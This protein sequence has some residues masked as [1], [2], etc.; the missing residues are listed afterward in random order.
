M[1]AVDAVQ[2]VIIFV[3]KFGSYI[4]VPIFLLGAFIYLNSTHPQY[5]VT[6]KIALKGV[7]PQSA[8]S[9]LRSKSTVQKVIDQLP[10]QA[11]YYDAE[12]LREEIS[13]DSL[14][15]R[16]VFDRTSRVKAETWVRFELPGTD[17]FTLSYIDTTAW[18]E[19]D[20]HISESYG[21]F[22]VVRGAKYNH[23][24]VSYMVRLQDPATLFNEYYHDLR[25]S[26]DDD[27]NSVTLS[28]RTGTPQKGVEFLNK[29]ISLYRGSDKADSRYAGVN[30]K[31][32]LSGRVKLLEKPEN[33]VELATA[34]PFWIYLAAIVAGLL[35]PLTFENA[36]SWRRKKPVAQ[37]ISL[38]KMIV[39]LQHGIAVRQW[40]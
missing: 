40:D 16:L 13:A 9:D 21:G 23:I 25:F 1:I 34:D 6:A 18:Y 15:A 8:I 38:P 2:R 27:E 12:S 26:S 20:K 33:N 17:V 29:M 7:T 31:A 10:L 28:I 35:V 32:T 11:S 30:G 36:K 24:P 4:F 37:I 19:F 3:K 22:K 5:R 14:K 39:R